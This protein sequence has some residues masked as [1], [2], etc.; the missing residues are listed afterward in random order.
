MFLKKCLDVG[1]IAPH[2]KINCPTEHITTVAAAGQ[3]LCS[4][5]FVY[6]RTTFDPTLHPKTHTSQIGKNYS[7]TCQTTAIVQV[8]KN[9]RLKS[10]DILRYT[11]CQLSF[12]NSVSTKKRWD[13]DWLSAH[14]VEEA[15]LRCT[16]LF[17][18]Q[19][20]YTFIL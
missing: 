11:T 7:R 6:I 15:N 10:Q 5:H 9:S 1:R 2:R 14:E 3:P 12:A 18:I 17:I 20:I 19:Q 16:H 4:Q 8:D 13:E